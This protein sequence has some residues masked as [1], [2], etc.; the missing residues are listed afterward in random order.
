MKPPFGDHAVVQEFNRVKLYFRRLET[1]ESRSRIKEF[2]RLA[3]RLRATGIEAAFDFVGS[4]NFGQSLPQSDVDCV[5]YYSCPIHG[6]IHCP[7]NCP[8]CKELQTAVF[9]GI[10]DLHAPLAY[11]VEFIDW[12]NL[13]HL[14][15]EIELENAESDQLLAF[16][17][18][19]SISRAVNARLLRPLQI[20]LT[21]RPE[22]IQRMKP[23]LW[24]IF[25]ALGKSSRHRLSFKKYQQ[26]VEGQGARLPDSIGEAIRLVLGFLLPGAAGARGPAEA[27]GEEPPD[28][29]N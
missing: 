29:R 15:R 13:A 19:R 3:L 27:A 28:D 21:E 16:A 4:L 5:L 10:A 1:D 14:R 22:L 7:D 2:R 20:D 23:K 6:E 9:E 24:E 18:Y 8:T 17:F 11:K 12:L 26:R 25:D